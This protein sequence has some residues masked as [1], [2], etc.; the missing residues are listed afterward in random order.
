MAELLKINDEIRKKLN[1]PFPKEAVKPHDNKPYLTTIKA[2]YITERLN[3]VFGIGRWTLKHE[4]VERTT[5]YVVVSGQIILTDYEVV[6]PIQYGGHKTTGKGTEIADGYKS[7]VTDCI[8]KCASYLEIGI[9]VFKGQP[10]KPKVDDSFITKAQ[11]KTLTD[12]IN[13]K[14]IE[15][16]K[17]FEYMEVDSV[18][19]IYST[20]YT[21][22]K[23]VVDGAKGTV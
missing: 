8:S 23:M 5:D 14:K 16:G 7:A 11:I 1:T 20:D 10:N 22:A 18:D 19:T 3:D 17:F 21:K 4:V 12:I 13:K 15:E 2:I 9:D 6:T